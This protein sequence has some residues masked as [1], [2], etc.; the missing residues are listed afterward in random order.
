MHRYASHEIL[1]NFLR[2]KKWRQSQELHFQFSSLSEK[3]PLRYS[4]TKRCLGCFQNVKMSSPCPKINRKCLGWNAIYGNEFS[5]FSSV[6]GSI[7]HVDYVC[8]YEKGWKTNLRES[9]INPCVYSIHAYCS[10]L[11][12]KN[13]R[14]FR[15]MSD[16]NDFIFSLRSTR[17][18]A[19]PIE[20]SQI[21]HLKKKRKKWY[22]P[23]FMV[24][25]MGLN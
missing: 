2:W 18:L 12:H 22:P 17:S 19:A 11:Q 10:T 13:Q 25:L 8:S 7:W 16:L 5:D 14:L 21:K 4:L 23:S 20:K 1:M 24:Y 3:F 6:F 9:Y 15:G